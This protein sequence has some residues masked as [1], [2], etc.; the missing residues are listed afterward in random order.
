MF[1]YAQKDPI[2]KRYTPLEELGTYV[3]AH[4]INRCHGICSAGV[5][6]CN[7]PFRGATAIVKK[8]RNTNTGIEYAVKTINKKV[9]VSVA[10]LYAC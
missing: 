9:N 3:R 5:T 8:Y 7:V 1:A 10:L 6:G 4:G 2:E